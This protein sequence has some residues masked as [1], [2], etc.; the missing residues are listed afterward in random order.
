MSR[1]A[2]ARKKMAEVCTQQNSAAQSRNGSPRLT[3]RATPE[4][5]RPINCHSPV[6]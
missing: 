4:G 1:L 2:R 6:A 3:R 5:R